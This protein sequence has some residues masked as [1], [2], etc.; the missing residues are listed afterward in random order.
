M[1]VRLNQAIVGAH[2]NFVPRQTVECSEARGADLIKAGVGVRAPADALVDGEFV[3][4]TPEEIE[5]AHEDKRDRFLLGQTHLPKAK[6]EE[7]AERAVK[8]APRTPEQVDVCQG[9]T[10]QGN[11]CKKAAL[12]GKRYCPKHTEEI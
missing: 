11:A 3:E 6:R 7:L 5:Q 1:N 8:P 10:A 9:T 2:F 4:D 12:P